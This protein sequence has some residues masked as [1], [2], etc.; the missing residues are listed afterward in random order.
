MNGDR[1][2]WNKMLKYNKQDVILLE[3][4]YKRFL[5]W[6]TNHPNYGVYQQKEHVCPNCGSTHLIKHGLRYTKTNVYQRWQCMNCYAYS[7]SIKKE[8][9]VKPTLKN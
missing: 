2:G 6:I 9:V 4:I 1:K 3:K 5:A 7:Q 8:N